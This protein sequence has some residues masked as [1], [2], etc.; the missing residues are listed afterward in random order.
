LI[1]QRMQAGVRYLELYRAVLA[2]NQ[3]AEW[4]LPEYA[5]AGLLNDA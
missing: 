2:S 5:R 4:V 1:I 3:A